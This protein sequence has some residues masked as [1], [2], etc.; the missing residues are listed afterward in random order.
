MKQKDSTQQKAPKSTRQRRRRKR[1]TAQEALDFRQQ[2]REALIEEIRLGV[3]RT[4]QQLVEDEVLELVGA[5]WS[6]KGDSPL[7]RGGGTDTRIFL[8]G[9]PVILPRTRVRDIEQ[10]REVA[11]SSVRALCSR[12][13]LDD[14]VKRLLVRGISTR[15]YEETLTQLSAGLGLKRSAV[16]SAFRRASQKDLDALNGRSLSEW[17]FAAV[18]VDGVS[19]KDHTCV[20]ALGV[21]RDGRKRILGLREGATE[22]AA[23]VTDLLESLLERGLTLPSRALFVLDGAKALRAAVERVLGERALIQR[24]I[25]HKLRNVLSYLPKRWHAETRRRLMAAWSMKTYAEAHRALHAALRWLDGISESAAASLREA[26]EETLTVHRLGITGALRRTLLTTNPIESAFDTVSQH[27]AR[28]KRWNGS[29]M[30]MRWAG[31]GLV[32][33]ESQFRRVKGYTALPQLIAALEN[34]D[35]RES[36]DVA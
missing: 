34:A 21:A 9:E 32:C 30:V 20:V 12:D 33:A 11:P 22:N 28:V 17:T 4:A 36:E 1:P 27:A 15:N 23:L 19:F 31:S 13:A 18:Y 7:R 8:D 35:L 25:L 26:L 5:P 10:G 3:V 24:C 29:A 16:S 6:R 14:D 2:V